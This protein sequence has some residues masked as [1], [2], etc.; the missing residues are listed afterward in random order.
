MKLKH[1]QKLT[2]FAALAVLFFTIPVQSQQSLQVLPRHVRSAVSGGQAALQGSLPLTQTMGLTL[3]LPLRN[4]AALNSLLSQL[5]DPSSPNYHHFL[6]VDEFTAQFGPTAEDYQTV[7]NFAKANGFSVVDTPANR[8]ILPIGGTVAQINTAFHVQMNNYRHPTEDRT[9]YSP[10]RDP[11][12]NLGVPVAH[13]VGLD[14]FSL[15]KP[16]IAQPQDGQPD[17]LIT[18][19]GPGGTSYL[20]SDMRA[21]YYG[22]TTLTGTG[23]VVG[24]LEF[25]GYNKSDVDLTFS[26][27]GQTYSVPVVNV[28]LDGATGA[29][30]SNSA[31]DV[32]DIVQ[33]IGLAPGLSQVRVYIGV[34]SDATVLNSIATENLAKQIGISW[35][36]ATADP[37]ADDVFF[38]EM[39]AQGQSVFAASGDHGAFDAAI[40]PTSIQPMTSTLR[41]WAEPI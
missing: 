10:D 17:P 14:N 41:R 13:I 1:I 35:S 32:L 12:L 28:L 20:G 16:M 23:Q 30:T 4:T 5:Y 36:W 21:A 18:G 29:A 25:G 22:G 9:F 34:I 7:V 39:A 27:A 31:E 40:S 15:P 26:N 3:V 24:L 2:F 37:T 11:S 6:S 8:L 33:A 38:Q 19:S